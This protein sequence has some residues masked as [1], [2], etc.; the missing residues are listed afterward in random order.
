MKRWMRGTTMTAREYEANLNGIHMLFGAMLGVV[1]ANT[2]SLSTFRYVMTIA[3][4]VG[5]VVSILYVSAS[6]HRLAYFAYAVGG[7][8]FLPYFM[9]A[10]LGPGDVMP[11]KLQPTL[12][13]W[14]LFVGM[15]E[16]LPRRT[17][18]DSE[19]GGQAEE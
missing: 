4:T 13:C 2:E 14:T 1:L 10:I 5:I 6:K 16:F 12:A 8:V 15:I 3:F 19:G 17:D 11:D 9:R 18:A 7:V